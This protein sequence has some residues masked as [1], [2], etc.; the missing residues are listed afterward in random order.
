[1]T[2]EN[3][4]NYAKEEINKSFQKVMKNNKVYNN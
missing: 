2:A 3:E 1:M 4:Y